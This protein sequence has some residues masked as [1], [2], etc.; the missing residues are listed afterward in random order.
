M[1]VLKALRNDSCDSIS[2]TEGE[3]LF[4]TLVHRRRIRAFRTE[5]WSVELDSS[6]VHTRDHG[7]EIASLPSQLH[8]MAVVGA[9]IDLPAVTA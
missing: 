3:K 5:F 9:I 8:S 6:A 4:Q 1:C 7:M 2:L